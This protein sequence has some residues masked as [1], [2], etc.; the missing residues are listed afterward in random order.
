[1]V[2]SVHICHSLHKLLLCVMFSVAIV[3]KLSSCFHL[4]T[5][6]WMCKKETD[7]C[8][9]FVSCDSTEF[10][11]K[12]KIIKNSLTYIYF[13][14]NEFPSLWMCGFNQGFSLLFQLCFVLCQS[15]AICVTVALNII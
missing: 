13:C 1:M 10:I 3:N 15:Y 5:L 14:K 6:L 9:D 2:F 11:Y 7:I 4:E 8:T 12:S